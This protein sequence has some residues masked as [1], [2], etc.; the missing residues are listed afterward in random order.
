MNAHK[1][2]LRYHSRVTTHL[3]GVVST[4]E[5]EDIKVE[6]ANVSRAGVMLLCDRE[7]VDRI[8]LNEMPVIPRQPIQIELGFSLPVVA[9]KHIAVHTPCNVVYVRRQSRD[10]FQIGLEFGDIEE[11]DYAYVDQYVHNRQASNAS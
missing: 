9:Q 4:D 5:G 1:R 10:L 8:H 6:V 3:D 11:R 2:N 7:T